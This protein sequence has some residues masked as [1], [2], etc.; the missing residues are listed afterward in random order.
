MKLQRLVLLD[1][2]RGIYAF[3][4]EGRVRYIG[5]AISLRHRIRQYNRALAPETSRKFRKVHHGIQQ[6]WTDHT[7]VDVWVYDFDESRDGSLGRLEAK[8]I[9]EKAPEWND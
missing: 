3:V 6:M 4:V 2:T 7:T 8:W 1:R 9:N 5:K